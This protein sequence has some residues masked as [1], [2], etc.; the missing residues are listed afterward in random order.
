VAAGIANSTPAVY[1][2]QPAWTA[3]IESESDEKAEA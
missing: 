1:S 3:F 2:L